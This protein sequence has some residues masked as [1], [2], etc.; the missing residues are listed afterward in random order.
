MR[1]VWF[2]S[3]LLALG[4]IADPVAVTDEDPAGAKDRLKNRSSISFVTMP[5]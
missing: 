5:L 4:C 2:S 1:A 3:G